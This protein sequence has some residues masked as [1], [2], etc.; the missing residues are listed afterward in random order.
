M[1]SLSVKL[2]TDSIFFGA[3]SQNLTFYKQFMR[4]IE[5]VVILGMETY[6][7]VLR[8]IKTRFFIAIIDLNVL[9]EKCIFTKLKRI[10][11]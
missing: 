9:H 5:N 3:I 1:R 7:F 10:I 11:Y 6:G 8:Q 4:Y 2:Y